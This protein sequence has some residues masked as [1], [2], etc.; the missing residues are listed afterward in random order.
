MLLVVNVRNFPAEDIGLRSGM[1]SL[2]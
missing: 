2:F 1:M